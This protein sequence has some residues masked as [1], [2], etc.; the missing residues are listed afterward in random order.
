[1]IECISPIDG[2]LLVSKKP[3]SESEIQNMVVAAK[4]AQKIWAK[5]PLSERISK[6]KQYLEN[7]R[8]MNDEIV[9]EIAQ[10]MGRPIRYGGEF[11]PF[12][13]RTNY[14]MNLAP[15]ALQN[16]MPDD[17]KSGI[18]RYIERAP[19]GIVMVI[20]PW[21]YPFITANNTI[22]TALLA[23]NAV[24]LKHSAQTILV[25]ERI[26]KALESVGLPHGLF[27]HVIMTHDSCEKLLGSG[28]INYVNFTGSVQ[29]GRN[30]EKA[31][32][33]TFGGCGLE[34]GG[35]DP[36]LVLDDCDFDF[37][38]ANLVDGA[39]YNSGQCCCGI[40]RIYVMASI[41]D[42]FVEKFAQLTNEY[43]L[44][45][46]LDSAT[47]LGPMANIRFANLVRDHNKS[48]IRD[49]A[50]A[51]IDAK[52]FSADDGKNCFVAPQ[53]MVNVNHNMD[54]MKEETFGPSVGIMKINNTDD[55]I[56]LMNDSQFGLTASIWTKDL[57]RAEQIG[58]Q[59]ET[60][61]VFMNRCD[62]VDPGL[63]WTGIK[64]TGRGAGLGF[65]GFDQVTR[66]KPFHLRYEY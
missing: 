55:A 42:K 62:Y 9:P 53:V 61:M 19:V 45:N 18:K 8:A 24:L 15:K 66:P 4:A 58:K 21:N 10:Q 28:H 23:G 41:Y 5:T 65:L 52:K 17:N 59:V 63:C 51:L 54:I 37:T 14:L 3:H 39:F 29:G 50:K 31:I 44:G 22:V 32:A 47:T 33:G 43:I 16:M 48:A 30:I 1:M 49:G 20:A 34:L 46:P 26:A 25:G 64:N 2:K 40:E 11:R 27:H 13:E 60:G 6:V 7:M 56:K 38:V 35:K 12:E 57:E 36:A